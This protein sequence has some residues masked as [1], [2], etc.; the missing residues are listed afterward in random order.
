MIVW[1]ELDQHH[2]K[3]CS[4]AVPSPWLNPM[5]TIQG[6]VKVLLS[7]SRQ[8]TEARF[9]SSRVPPRQPNDSNSAVRASPG[10][11]DRKGRSGGP[12][13]AD[14]HVKHVSA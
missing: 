14:G 2:R 4:L 13:A 8:Q 5:E 9:N 3:Q 11:T 12:A 1:D 6:W 10:S 7:C